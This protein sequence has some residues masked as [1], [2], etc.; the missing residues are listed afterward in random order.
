[1]S[2]PAINDFVAEHND[3]VEGLEAPSSNHHTKFD[4]STL[5]ERLS[6]IKTDASGSYVPLMEE[7][8]EEDDGMSVHT[9][10]GSPWEV[11]ED[12]L[13]TPMDAV[14]LN[15][16]KGRELLP[17]V[18][19][20]SASASDNE[21]EVAQLAASL[22]AGS[23]KSQDV[24]MT[25]VTFIRSTAPSPAPSAFALA[26]M[27]T[28]QISAA[29]QTNP[30]IANVAAPVQANPVEDTFTEALEEDLTC[31]IC[32]EFFLAPISL[33][34][35]H[36]FC[37]MC[38]IPWWKEGNAA[39]NK[40][41][42]CQTKLA[43][44]PSEVLRTLDA[45]TQS[46]IRHKKNKMDA[47]ELQEFSETRKVKEEESADLI[48]R[49]KEIA[50]ANRQVAGHHRARDVNAILLR[51]MQATI[52][53]VRRAHRDHPRAPLGAQLLLAC[54]DWLRHFDRNNAPE[55]HDR[56]A[57]IVG[58]DVANT[59]E[60][61][62]NAMTVDQYL[63]N[64]HALRMRDQ[65]GQAAAHER[66]MAQLEALRVQAARGAQRLEEA[67]RIREFFLR[68]Q[69][70]DLEL[71]RMQMAVDNWNDAPAADRQAQA[72]NPLPRQNG[73][74][75]PANPPNLRD[76]LPAQ[77]LRHVQA[78]F[79]ENGR[80][81]P[82]NRQAEA[83]QD[84]NA[85]P[86]AGEFDLNDFD[87]VA[88]DLARYADRMAR[89]GQRAHNPLPA[90]AIRAARNA[91]VVIQANNQANPAP[92]GPRNRRVRFAPAQE[93]PLARRVFNVDDG[94]EEDLAIPAD[95]PAHRL[96]AAP[97]PIPP[98]LQRVRRRLGL[99]DEEMDE[100]ARNAQAMGV[101]LLPPRAQ[102]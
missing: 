68:D 74:N 100:A 30:I 60:A 49:R 38:V 9:A 55:V 40:C 53:I 52:D 69:I 18:D 71:M 63:V 35:G 12:V 77:V 5:S 91:R 22:T 32:M 99:Q 45:L 67:N 10:I 62:P 20:P 42:Y 65:G 37:S 78:R 94:V 58:A 16:G 46:F 66:R 34:C 92:V 19:S 2:S 89:R 23:S 70:R 81:N 88:A 3:Y 98:F 33:Q 84:G 39:D 83:G 27:P 11:D 80:P 28:T 26:A 54:Q 17:D 59:A 51:Q 73:A 25:E 86:A 7:E 75:N 31:S 14:D 79:E 43:S 6:A 4:S 29:T 76:M 90:R 41:P 50:K 102:Q 95:H 24:E 47:E 13:D 57:D 97:A 44:P 87:G 61:G 56:L 82:E 93:A 15:K 85:G 64:H 8:I 36:S 48:S 21:E 101:R 72:G 1:M 96:R